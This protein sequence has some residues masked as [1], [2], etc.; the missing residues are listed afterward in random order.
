[1]NKILYKSGD[2]EGPLDLMLHLIR[3]NKINIQNICISE[4]LEQY[5]SHINDMT[6]NNMDISS[7][8]LEM[9]AKLVYIKT[10][11][12]LPKKDEA[13][14]LK[15][16]LSEQIIEYQECKRLAQALKLKENFDSFIRAP[17][18]LTIK[19]SIYEKTHNISELLNAYIKAKNSSKS[20]TTGLDKKFSVIVS[21]KIVSVFSKVIFIFLTLRKNNVYPYSQFFSSQKEKSSVIATFLAILE[22]IKVKRVL[23]TEEN[24]GE[25]CILLN[26]KRS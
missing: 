24:Q 12:L 11:S 14:K 21:K 7:E 1:M 9:A 23:L 26:K 4:L 18:K 13:E 3:K 15:K 20:Q 17:E 6:K 10:I 25:L 8:F 19:T 5:M 22:L 2:F 16:E